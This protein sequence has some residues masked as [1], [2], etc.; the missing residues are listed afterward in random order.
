MTVSRFD[1]FQELHRLTAEVFDAVRAPRLAPLDVYRHGDSYVLRFDLPGVAEESLEV[2]AENQTLTVRAERRSDAPEG[3][4]YV[5]AER[6]TGVYRR[7]IVLGDGL[8]LDRISAD[9]SDGVLTVTIPIADR[10]KPRKI[11]VTRGGN[12]ASHR[13]IPGE[14]REENAEADRQPVGAGT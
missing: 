6:P 13:V 11:A 7:Q 8:D 5:T 1:P 3:A 4:E 14:F 2:T 12:L 9:Y 10:A